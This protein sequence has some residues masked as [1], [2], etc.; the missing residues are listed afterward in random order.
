MKKLFAF[1][2][3]SLSVSQSFAQSEMYGG[4]QTTKDYLSQSERF[5][6]TPD[7]NF[8]LFICVGQ[9]NMEGAAKPEEQ[10]YAW[11]NERFQVM[12]ATDY[13]AH[14]GNNKGDARK[15]Y[16]WYTAVP[17]LCRQYAGLTPADYFGRTLVETLPDSIRIGVIHVA[18]GGCRIEHLFKEYDPQ[19]VTREP[20]WFQG[21]MNDYDALPYTRVLECALRAS[22]QGVFKGILLHQGCSN[23]G[24]PEW[25]DKVNKLY[26]DLLNDLH[27]NAEQVPLIAGEVVGKEAGGACASMNAIIQTLPQTIPTSKV[28]SSEG[29]PGLPDHLHFT[30]EGY[31]EIGK[32]YAAAWLE[33]N[34]IK[35]NKHRRPRR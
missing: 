34:K 26:R 18:I 5:A 10:D 32:R 31:R 3:L 2:L 6:S 21:I 28:V 15:K 20:D 16:Q 1:L 12:A 11:D 17:P 14:T 9:S 8:Y 24:D 4:A 13:A 35:T 23:T 22:H 30:A 33:Y 27:L 7:P 19:S 29:L 25:P